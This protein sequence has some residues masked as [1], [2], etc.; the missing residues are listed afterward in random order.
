MEEIETVCNDL[1]SGIEA[2]KLR[3]HV[4]YSDQSMLGEAGANA[5]LAYRHLE[6]AR[7][8]IG[9]ILQA[10]DGG[11]SCYDKKTDK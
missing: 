2:I 5:L 1:R 6:D 4:L 7:M 10:L 11:V 3:V 8:R 9:K